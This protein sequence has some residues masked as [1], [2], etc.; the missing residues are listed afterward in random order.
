MGAE[1]WELD[2]V[3][4]HQQKPGEYGGYGGFLVV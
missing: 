2:V 4:G 1:P 3:T